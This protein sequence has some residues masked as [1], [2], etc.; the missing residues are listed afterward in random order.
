MQ[1]NGW[2][3]KVGWLACAGTGNRTSA[4]SVSPVERHFDAATTL[5][6]FDEIFA[7]WVMHR[8]TM[9][10]TPT[11]G[12]FR[13]AIGL[14]QG[15]LGWLLLRLV[16]PAN[17][18][19]AKHTHAP[20]WSERHPMLFAA[21]ALTTAYVPVIVIAEIGRIRRKTL[22]TYLMLATAALAGLSAYDLW[23]EPT[24]HWGSNAIR[25][26]P[27]FQLFLCAAMGLFIV[28]QLLEHRE[29]GHA[30]F[31]QY[32]E[33]FE[34]SWMR[35]FQLFVSLVFALLVWGVLTLGAELF[36]L[37]H[38][39]WV[40]SM[41]EHNWFRCPALAMAF[42]AAMHITD[43]RPALL[44]GM[45]NVVLTLLSWL[46]PLIVSLGLGFLIALVFVGLQP[47]WATRHAASILLWACVLTIFLLNA[48]YKDGDPSNLPSGFLRWAGRVAGPTLLLLALLASYAIALRVS[49]YGWTPDRVFSSAVAIVTLIYGGGYTYAVIDRVRWLA[50]L[51]TVN[52]AASF[53]IIVI[54]AL[55]LSPA[56]DP[57]RLSVS[58]QMSRLATHKV[59]S[60]KFDYQ[61]LRFDSG[62]YGRNGLTQ[63]TRSADAD[64]RSR[65][66]QMQLAKARH[67]YFQDEPSAAA[68]EPAF[69]HATI[70]PEGAQLPRDFKS[71]DWSSEPSFNLNCLQN[72]ASCDIY[73]VPYGGAAELAVIV[74]Q[75]GESRGY[76]AGTSG[77]LYQ[78]DST[79][80][81]MNTGSFNH[82]D[83]PGVVSTLRKGQ[84]TL[85]RSEH[86]DLMAD[87][88]RLEF[89]A[90]LHGNDHQCAP[91][92]P[93]GQL[94]PERVRDSAAPS[95][96]G[97]AFGSPG[98]R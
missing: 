12:R 81:W 95:Y 37:I 5:P 68:T 2:P 91:A 69:L 33:H 20:Y 28:N 70:Y 72:G 59:S 73:I 57:A 53:V 6:A 40:R 80:K 35:G 8:I 62:T 71:S 49:Q 83:C 9:D 29:R 96:M 75:T 48:A 27:S 19:A 94:T 78:R 66:A 84:L 87:G 41:V 82:M 38:V 25:V 67:Y 1:R 32:A 3:S 55:L 76:N 50:L 58:S 22:L 23:R 18:L 88:V 24:E 79:G 51:E 64:V 14:L 46:L 30:L 10:T 4:R 17:Y 65:A 74:R 85:A 11:V 39:A 26:W 16:P 44:K 21:L 90:S 92:A 36:D 31:S 52:V 54:L 61:F 98:G 34:D 63:L 47:L 56:A 97:P 60:E 93:S 42:G 15:I 43:V 45:R 77:L 13:I 89:S 7:F 86:D